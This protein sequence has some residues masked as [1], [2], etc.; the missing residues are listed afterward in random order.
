MSIVM[1]KCPICSSSLS[2]K[3]FNGGK[4]TLS[5]LGWPSTHSEAISMEKYPLDGP[6]V[7]VVILP[8]GAPAMSMRDNKGKGEVKGQAGG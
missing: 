8:T 1:K 6:A 4:K 7:N 5:T 2:V 3:V